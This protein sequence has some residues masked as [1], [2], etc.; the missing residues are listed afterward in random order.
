MCVRVVTTVV[1]HLH[2]TGWG[3]SV[4]ACTQACMLVYGALCLRSL[5]FVL[6]IVLARDGL[7]KLVPQPSV[8]GGGAGLGYTQG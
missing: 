8:L 1:L 2:V 6:V 3:G 7:L 4:R 5:S